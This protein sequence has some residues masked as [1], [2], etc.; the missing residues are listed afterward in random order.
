MKINILN[1]SKLDITSDCKKVTEFFKTR[2]PFPV[3]FDIQNT[4]IPIAITAYKQVQG[5]NPTTG[6]PA[7]VTYYG[8][9]DISYP[10]EIFV[11]DL[12]DALVPSGSVVTSWTDSNLFIQLAIN[13]YTHDKGETW[14]KLSHELV[15][16]LVYKANS[17]GFNIKDEMDLTH[18]NQAFYKNDDPYA[19]DGNYALTL[20]NLQLYFNS[21]PIYKYF[22]PSEIVGLKP[23]LVSLL[24]KMRGECGFPFKINSGFR[25]VAQNASLSD[26]VGDSAHLTGLAVDL[27]IK[28]SV[29]RLKLLQVALNNEIGR[30]GI[31]KDFIHIDISK[32]LPINVCWLY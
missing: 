15:H 27:S 7:L 6:K 18:N 20:K 13:Q 2:I 17:L 32:I 19:L 14:K 24:D 5:F 10:N 3:E 25:T 9:K 22:K 26:S 8:L 12:D 29:K 28:D 1:S 11:Y 4:N 23:E 31:G 21:T 30:I 16:F